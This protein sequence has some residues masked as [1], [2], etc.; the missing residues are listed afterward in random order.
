MSPSMS[1]VGASGGGELGAEGPDRGAEG[2]AAAADAHAQPPPAHLHRAH[3][4]HQDARQRGEPPAGAAEGQ[5]KH[6][7]R[8]EEPTLKEEPTPK[9]TP[10]E[11]LKE[12]G[13]TK[14]TK[15]GTLNHRIGQKWRGN[16]FFDVYK[17]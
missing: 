3:R 1:G 6:S 11:R 13:T 15:R 14:K 16:L 4:Q 7:T 10:S 12:K 9:G 5:V 2:G 17:K 8:H